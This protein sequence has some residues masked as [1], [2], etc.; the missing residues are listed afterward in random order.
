MGS[1]ERMQKYSLQDMA[2]YFKPSTYGTS[3]VTYQVDQRYWLTLGS[4]DAATLQASKKARKI[5]LTGV[6]TEDKDGTSHNV[7]IGLKNTA[8][9]KSNVIKVNGDGQAHNFRFEMK[10]P[11]NTSDTSLV[12][13]TLEPSTTGSIL[14]TGM[15]LSVAEEVE[16]AWT[17]PTTVAG[18][19]T[20]IANWIRSRESSGG[21]INRLLSAFTFLIGGEAA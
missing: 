17:K 8:N 3:S 10:I 16:A 6:V 7:Y 20:T 18:C 1:G 11:K 5:V 9:L 4:C 14:F 15:Q 21:V 13:R 19:L 2:I 12:F